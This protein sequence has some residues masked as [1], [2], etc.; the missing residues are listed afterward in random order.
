MVILL[1][2]EQ[3]TAGASWKQTQQGSQP[4]IES[5]VSM[6]HVLKKKKMKEYIS[7]SG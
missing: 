4:Y 5:G 6:F 2:V 7:G 3:K 1:W